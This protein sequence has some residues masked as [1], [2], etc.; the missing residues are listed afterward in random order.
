MRRR[1]RCCLLHIVPSLCANEKVFRSLLAEQRQSKLLCVPFVLT[2]R[3]IALATLPLFWVSAMTSLF[4][5]AAQ[6][7]DCRQINK[8]FR[9]TVLS[10]RVASPQCVEPSR[11][12]GAL[13]RH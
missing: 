9:L 11:T 6:S 3:R 7:W 8:Q 13:R 10:S 5:S 1:C 2:R 12:C 4:A